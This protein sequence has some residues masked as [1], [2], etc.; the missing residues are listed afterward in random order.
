L[1]Q[2]HDWHA[3]ERNFTPGDPVIVENF[4]GM[5]KWKCGEVTEKTGP[6]SYRVVFQDGTTGRRH[7]DH[8]KRRKFLPPSEEDRYSDDE[9]EPKISDT[10]P[11]ENPPNVVTPSEV[12]HP[13]I[14]LPGQQQESEKNCV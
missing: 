14:P 9:T 6:V 3:K 13:E 4:H 5:Q 7:I 10:T 12:V 11:T 8:L 2:Y 1:K